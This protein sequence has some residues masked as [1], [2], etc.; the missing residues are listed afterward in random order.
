LSASHVYA[1]GGPPYFTNDPGTP[2]NRQ[3]EINIGFLPVPQTDQ[4]TTRLPDL[5][6]NFGVG[7]RVQLTLE[8][9]WLRH[10]AQPSPAE[11]GLSQDTI[12][13]KW[14]PYGDDEGVALSVFPQASVNNP[15]SSVTR[16]V[17]P[18][19]ASLTLP[20]EMSKTFG[21]LAVN[22]EAGY[23]IVQS[24]RNGW[25]AGVVAG[26]G[27]LIRHQKS[28]IEF[29]AEFYTAGDIGGEV[30][31]K[32]LEGGVRFEVQPPFVILAMAGW[33]LPHSQGSLTA[34]FGLQLLLPPKP[35]DMR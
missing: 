32:T 20:L 29:D 9:G 14:R 27:R 23:T 25:L 31:Q 18:P 11:Y 3:W 24:G 5:D 19:G 21:L 26:H 12:G 22:G 13:I 7:D 2:G 4:S 15:T 30:T 28:S 17:V 1:Q 34:Y 16:G 35:T 6:L 8:L 10:R 33:S